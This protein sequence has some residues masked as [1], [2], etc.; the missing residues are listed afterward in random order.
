M[1][2]PD[3][4]PPRAT[5]EDVGGPTP[6]ATDV[7]AGGPEVPPDALDAE[8]A[9]IEWFRSRESALIGY[10]GGVDSTYLAA[11]AL[12]ALGPERMVAVLGV[13]AS[14]PTKQATDARERAARLGLPLRE[15]PTYELNDPEYAAN[16]ANRCFHCKSELWSRLTPLARELEFAVVCDGTNADDVREYRPGMRAASEGGVEAPLADVGLTKAAIRALSRK[17]GRA[18][19]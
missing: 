8:R 16:P 10:S 14:V 5:T 19:V 4:L 3:V 7:E 11:V 6:P 2:L 1:Q 18:H 12:E 9:L 15:M 13:S 17:I